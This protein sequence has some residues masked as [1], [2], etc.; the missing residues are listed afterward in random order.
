MSWSIKLFKY[1]YGSKQAIRM[2]K[3]NSNNNDETVV[4][5][6]VY[7]NIGTTLTVTDMWTTRS[8]LRNLEWNLLRVIRTD[9]AGELLTRVM[10]RSCLTS[11][12]RC[13]DIL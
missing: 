9:T 12:I 10:I 8:L 3:N 13:I 6:V 4:H 2:L 1:S 7:D 5:F 11:R